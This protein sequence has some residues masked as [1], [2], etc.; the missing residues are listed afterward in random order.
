MAAAAGVV[1]TAVPNGTR[2]Y[3]RYVVVDHGNGE[4]SLYAHLQIVNVG[5]GQTVDQGSLVGLVG[6]TGNSTGPHLH[7]EERLNGK[8]VAPYFHGGAFAFGSSAQSQNCPD[9]PLAGNFV[10]DGIAE[11]AV[12]DRATATFQISQPTGPLVV[13]FGEGTDTPVVGDWNGDGIADVGVRR[14]STRSFYLNTPPVWSSVVMGNRSD[15]PVAGDWDGNGVWDIGVRKASKNVFR[16]R[17]PDGKSIPVRLGKAGDLPVTGDWNG[18]GAPTWASTTYQGAVHPAHQGRQRTRLARLASST[19]RRAICR[20]RATG[21]ATAAPTS[22][23]GSRRRLSSSSASLLADRPG[24][25]E[26]P[27]GPTAL[28]FAHDSEQARAP[29]RG[30]VRRRCRPRARTAPRRPPSPRRPSRPG[31]RRGRAAP[32]GCRPR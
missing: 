24:D 32:R 27:R 30:G 22:A 6:D 18:D 16:L 26:R 13:S 14:A 8:T 23:C 29:R 5:V 11:L 31:R 3:G 7:F 15:L 1:T 10:G 21:T 28:T 20:S 2:G 9:V 12:F 17:K 4:S 25:Q 19:A